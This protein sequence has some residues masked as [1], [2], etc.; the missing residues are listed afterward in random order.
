MVSV[1][2]WVG[3]SDRPRKMSTPLPSWSHLR[4]S[5][6]SDVTSSKVD[7][8]V[9][10][11][12]WRNS[13]LFWIKEGK[14]TCDHCSMLH[15][16]IEGV[17]GIPIM[18]SDPNVQH[19]V[20]QEKGDGSHCLAERIPWAAWLCPTHDWSN[21]SHG[22]ESSWYSSGRPLIMNDIFG[23]CPTLTELPREDI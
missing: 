1:I 8:A 23:C 11:S 3:E 17:H 12:A 18:G 7:E 13:D 21:L 10:G 19:G 4:Y 16:K 2:R 5:I 22:I 20:Q 14:E 9:K 6:Y 15:C